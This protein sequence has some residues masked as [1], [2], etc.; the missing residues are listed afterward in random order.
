MWC[1]GDIMASKEF[2]VYNVP[3]F[4]GA[5]TIISILASITLAIYFG[6][7]ANSIGFISAFIFMVFSV[8]AFLNFTSNIEVHKIVGQEFKY[9][10]PDEDE[11]EETWERISGR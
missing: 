4:I 10:S 6:N 7:T 1:E 2:R 8:I 3:T 9:I 5:F 11:P